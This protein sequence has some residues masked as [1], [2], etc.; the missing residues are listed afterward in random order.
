[1]ETKTPLIFTPNSKVSSIRRDRLKLLK[2]Q[3]SMPE[4][5]QE[6]ERGCGRILKLAS[7]FDIFPLIFPLG[8]L[9]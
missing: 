1:M 8:K 7:K 4:A 5:G 2:D 6:D 9:M 3:N